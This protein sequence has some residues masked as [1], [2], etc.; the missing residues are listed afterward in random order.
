MLRSGN[1]SQARVVSIANLNEAL[2]T[3]GRVK[4]H[5]QAREEDEAEVG[6][7][8]ELKATVIDTEVLPVIGRLQASWECNAPIRSEQHQE[9]YRPVCVFMWLHAWCEKSNIQF[10]AF[11]VAEL[12]LPETI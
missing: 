2:S 8:Q 4:C 3:G 1:A 7:S 10:L 9:H 11:V 5:P 6:A 12:R